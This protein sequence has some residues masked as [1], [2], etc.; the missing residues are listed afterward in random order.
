[1][2]CVGAPKYIVTLSQRYTHIVTIL[3]R[4]FIAIVV[5]TI[6][7]GGGGGTLSIISALLTMAI[8]ACCIVD[9]R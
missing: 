8:H 2:M 9:P 5:H 6:V 7:W 4:I 1:M 3:R